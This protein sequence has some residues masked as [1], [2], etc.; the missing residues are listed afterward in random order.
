MIYWLKESWGLSGFRL[1]S[2]SDDYLKDAGE[3]CARLSVLS[4]GKSQCGRRFCCFQCG[5]FTVEGGAR[6]QRERTGTGDATDKSLRHK[7]IRTLSCFAILI[8][9]FCA[10]V[11]GR[12]HAQMA[13]GTVSGV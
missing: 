5:I 6:A 12:L 10:P 9:L 13:G 1:S 3:T 7:G 4:N 2:R 8:F 11:T